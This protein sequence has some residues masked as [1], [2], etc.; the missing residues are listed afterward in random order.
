MIPGVSRCRF[1]FLSQDLWNVIER[2]KPTLEEGRSNV[3]LEKNE[4]YK[5]SKALFEGVVCALTSNK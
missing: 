2:G 3:G 4:K 1:F 5:A